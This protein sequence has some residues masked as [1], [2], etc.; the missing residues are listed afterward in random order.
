[1]NLTSTRAQKEMGPVLILCNLNFPWQWAESE[2][3]WRGCWV[4]AKRHSARLTKQHPPAVLFP[5]R[6]LFWTPSRECSDSSS[7]DLWLSSRGD[8]MSCLIHGVSQAG[9]FI[10]K[11]SG[12]GGGRGGTINEPEIKF[13]C[14]NKTIPLCT[15]SPQPESEMLG[16][17]CVQKMFKAKHL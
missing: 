8:L 5:D 7:L 2:W 16:K 6:Y 12:G 11:I 9:F 15:K 10:V 1:M 3:G 17:V 13:E 14:H 4:P